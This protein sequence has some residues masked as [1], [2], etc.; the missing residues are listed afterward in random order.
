MK[1]MLKRNAVR[2]ISA[3]E[4]GRY[5]GIKFYIAHHDVLSPSSSSTP[6]REVFNRSANLKGG[7]ALT[8]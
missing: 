2:Y 7:L 3:E 8:V 4:L 5:P 1:D 6:M